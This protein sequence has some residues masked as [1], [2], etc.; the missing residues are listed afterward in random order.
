MTGNNGLITQ[1][2]RAKE[3][4][5][6]ST[7]DELRRL[8]ALEA[9]TYLEEHE[10][11]DPS[12]KNIT[13]P[14]QCA[15]SQVE[16]ENTLEDGLVVIDSNGNEWVW[17]EVPKTEEVYKTAGLNVTSFTDE[18][19]TKIYEDLA[20]Y[21]ETY[22][23]E[24][25]LDVWISEE[26]FG[27][28]NESEYNKLKNKML[29]SINKNGGFYVGRYEIGSFDEP[30]KSNNITRKVVIQKGSYPYNFITCKQAQQ[31]ANDLNPS[32]N[33][34][35][36]SSL[37]FGIQWDLVCKYL[38]EKA[39]IEENDIKVNSD[40]WGNYANS[41]II[42][43]DGK[44]AKYEDTTGLGSWDIIPQEFVK[45]SNER[46]LF[47]TGASD[48]MKKMNIYDFAGNVYEY[49]LSSWIISTTYICVGRG[50]YFGTQTEVPASRLWKIQD[51]RYW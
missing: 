1:V 47:T 27:I 30:V 18:E 50:G 20:S 4:T 33:E 24:N 6:Q 48:Y 32:T 15:V 36:T 31:L 49:T 2:N 46:I 12:G 10:Y 43:L 8:T 41:E 16:G 23:D 28:A 25:Y 14:A 26:Q 11:K 29:K 38:E 39:D 19:C 22:R 7:G 9:K 13:I 51:W 40:S 44:Y 37:M 5:E 45:E 17:I 3:E 35:C 42:N 21:T 34:N